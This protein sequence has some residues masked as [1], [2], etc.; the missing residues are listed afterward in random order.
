MLV[1]SD[2]T[3][4]GLEGAARLAA[5]AGRMVAATWLDPAGGMACRPER[6]AMVAGAAAVARAISC[7]RCRRRCRRV[8]RLGNRRRR[9]RFR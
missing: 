5:A 2:G 7:V 1:N 8:D 9:A 4:Q 3:S 6:M